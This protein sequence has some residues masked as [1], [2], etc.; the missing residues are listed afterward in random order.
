M[1]KLALSKMI[2]PICYISIIYGSMDA[3]EYA[4]LWTFVQCVDIQYR[5]N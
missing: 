2:V 1:L 5:I 3:I 4:I